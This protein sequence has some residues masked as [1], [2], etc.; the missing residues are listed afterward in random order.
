MLQYLNIT[1]CDIKSDMYDYAYYLTITQNVD[2]VMCIR[3]YWTDY[4][5]VVPNKHSYMFS[6][7]ATAT[8]S[9]IVQYVVVAVF[10]PFDHVFSVNTSL[11]E[12]VKLPHLLSKRNIYKWLYFLYVEMTYDLFIFLLL[13][14]DYTLLDLNTNVKKIHGDVL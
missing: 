14:P 8:V 1:L 2:F 9:K 5:C 7:S 11:W 12:V 4:W 3:H 13:P 6:S 10:L